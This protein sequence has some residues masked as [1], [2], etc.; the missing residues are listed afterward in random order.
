MGHRDD[1]HC[2]GIDPTG[3]FCATGEIGPNPRLF[4][5]NSK[6]MEEVYHATAPLTKGIKHVAFS[7]DGKYLACSDMSDDHN[8]AIFDCK[9][10]LKAG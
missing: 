8:I 3:V 10:K 5:W 9:V 6:T 2:L 1:I 4:V 7:K